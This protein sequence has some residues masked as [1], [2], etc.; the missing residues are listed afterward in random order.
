MT[1]TFRLER[2]DG[3]PAEPLTIQSTVTA[4]STDC[5]ADE[6]RDQPSFS[7]TAMRS[8]SSRPSSARRR[9]SQNSSIWS[10]GCGY[11]RSP[12]STA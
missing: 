7:Q 4:G 5:R 6:Q 3:T 12:G 8:P 9:A 1:F 10:G 11:R 2:A